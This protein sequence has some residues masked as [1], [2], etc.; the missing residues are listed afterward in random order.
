MRSKRRWGARRH[1]S[2]FPP[3]M[4]LPMTPTPTSKLRIVVGVSSSEGADHGLCEAMRLAQQVRDSELH[5]THVIKS[6]GKL[7]DK[8]KL[9]HLSDDLRACID[10]LRNHVTRVCAPAHETAAFTQATVFH[11]R[12]GDP[13]SALIQVAVDVDADMIVVG[14]REREAADKP[15]LGP[16]V[17]ALTRDAPLTVVVVHPKDLSGRQ[18]TPHMD[19]ARPG[20]DFR[21]HELSARVH[22]EFLPRTSHIS[23]L[24]YV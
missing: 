1:V 10:D 8:H 9:A 11:V 13:A 5:V 16:V 7:H 19:P 17:E 4:S 3:L 24:L 18:K 15:T 6:D 2:C 12:I 21:Q 23:G 22:L 20:D 14:T